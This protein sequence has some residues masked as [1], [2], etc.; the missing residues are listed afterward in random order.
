MLDLTIVGG[1]M[2]RTHAWVRDKLRCI[3][4]KNMKV[5]ER[6]QDQDIPRILGGNKFSG[7]TMMHRMKC[8]SR[9]RYRC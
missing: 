5:L 6:V 8:V 2:D 1:S 3:D 7:M 4:D 9:I